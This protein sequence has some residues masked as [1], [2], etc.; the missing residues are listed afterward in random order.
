MLPGETAW[1][2]DHR[3]GEQAILPATGL[4]EMMLAAGQAVVPGW[5]AL[6][7]LSIVAP[8]VLAAAGTRAVQTV[9]DQ[10]GDG[11][12]QVR[13]FAAEAEGSLPAVC[14]GAA[15]T[16]GGGTGGGG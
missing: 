2:G 9:V 6:A 12:L 4:I 8:V 1:L 16:G 11:T 7:G 13:V 14:R 5:R 15:G 10:A 3:I